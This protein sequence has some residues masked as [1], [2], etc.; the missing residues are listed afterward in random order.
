MDTQELFKDF[1]IVA[2][3][4]YKNGYGK[5]FGDVLDRVK[6]GSSMLLN[7]I[8]EYL[9]SKRRIAECIEFV[10]PFAEEDPLLISM[11]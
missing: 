5:R 3:Q 6:D 8:S 4:L 10:S 7:K 1:V 9:I 2:T 11:I